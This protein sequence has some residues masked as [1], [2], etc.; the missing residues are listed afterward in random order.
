V[1][2]LNPLVDWRDIDEVLQHHATNIRDDRTI[3]GEQLPILW[4]PNTMLVSRGRLALSSQIVSATQTWRQPGATDA[5]TQT[6]GANPVN[7]LVPGLQ[8]LSSPLIDYLASVTGSRFD[9]A[10]DW[11]LGDF[12]KQFVWQEIWPLQTQRAQQNDEAQFRR[13]IVARFKVRYYG[14]ISALDHRYVVKSN[15]A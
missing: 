14:G 2:A 11:F 4:M 15:A 7:S 6:I 12:K 9:D 8:V 5:T 13:D 1:T 3:T 10:A